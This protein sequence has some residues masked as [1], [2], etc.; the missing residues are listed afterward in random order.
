M[1]PSEKLLGSLAVTV[2]DT[3]VFGLI[4]AYWFTSPTSG[5]LEDANET[6]CSSLPLTSP[7]LKLR[8]AATYKTDSD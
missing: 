2:T 5:R 8:S 1:T 4:A 6:F 7:H 3:D